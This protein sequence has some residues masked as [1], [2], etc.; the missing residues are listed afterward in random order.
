MA[1]VKDQLEKAAEPGL[2][3]RIQNVQAPTNGAEDTLSPANQAA[4]APGR[5]RTYLD[6]GS[7]VNGKLT[8]ETPVRIDGQVE[9]EI[10]AH[11]TSVSIGKSAMVTAKI[12]AVTVTVAGAVNGEIS[13]SQRIELLPS[14]KVS[15]TLAAPKLV[16]QEGAVFDGS[17]MMSAK[18]VRDER[19]P[20]ATRREERPA[21]EIGNQEAPGQ[22]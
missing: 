12:K 6:Q 20:G 7:K 13:A 11:D 2:L 10:D 8:F 17:C 5:E 1:S 22:V 9:G 15:G 19:K 16:V 18:A 14:A 3:S 4:I 21:A